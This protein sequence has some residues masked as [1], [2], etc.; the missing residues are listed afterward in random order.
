MRNA[1]IINYWLK[2]FTLRYAAKMRVI[3][4]RKLG[5]QYLVLNC[6]FFNISFFFPRP[7]KHNFREF[8]I[9]LKVFGSSQSHQ[10]IMTHPN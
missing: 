2:M 7:Q 8:L 1:V 9:N 6:F 5:I 4:G 10:L 3:L